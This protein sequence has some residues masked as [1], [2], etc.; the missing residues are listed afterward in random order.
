MEDNK[1]I[2]NNMQYK[3]CNI[4][5]NFDNNIKPTASKLR[6]STRSAICKINIDL[7]KNIKKLVLVIIMNIYHNIIKKNNLDYPIIGIQYNDIDIITHKKKKKRKNS[8]KKKRFYNQVTIIIKPNKNIRPINLKLFFNSSLSM[9]GCKNELDGEIA[10][11]TLLNEIKKYKC[12]FNNETDRNELNYYDY[13][14]TLINT[15]YSINFNIN[16]IKLYDLLIIKY[17]LFVT[18]APDIYP[19]I[20]IYYMW[21]TNN[22]YKN[23]LCNCYEEND[24]ICTGKGEGLTVKNCKRVTIAIFQS[25]K[26]IITGAKKIVQ[27]VDAYNFINKI[28]IKHYKELYKFSINNLQT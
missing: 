7:R 28:L 6:V 12:I 24:L 21:N 19:G 26:I 14:I 25:G 17:K 13:R 3:T 1:I 2:L 11:N 8:K 15:D 10:V 4:L 20:K 27:T 22:K 18:Y 9:T 23:G 16:R 5:N